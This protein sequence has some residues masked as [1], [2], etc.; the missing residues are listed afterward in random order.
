MDGA[1]GITSAYILRTE[2]VNK[3]RYQ[4][5]HYVNGYPISVETIDV[6]LQ[7]IAAVYEESKLSTPYKLKILTLPGSG[8]ILRGVQK[9]NWLLDAMGLQLEE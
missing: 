5:G 9:L 2:E 3:L 7:N 1:V 4:N 8:I 6:N